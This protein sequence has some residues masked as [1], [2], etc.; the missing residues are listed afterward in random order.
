MIFGTEARNV[1]SSLKDR[2]Y[3]LRAC[4]FFIVVSI[5]YGEENVSL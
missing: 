5:K 3:M 1:E 4:A 2:L